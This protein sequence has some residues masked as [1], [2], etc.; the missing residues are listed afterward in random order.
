MS[1]TGPPNPLPAGGK[2]S[3]NCTVIS[4]FAPTVYW[5]DPNSQV[6]T[7]E[8]TYVKI[9]SPVTNGNT[10]Y[11]VLHFDAINTSHG[12]TYACISTVRE[13]GSFRRETRYIQV[14]SE[15]YLC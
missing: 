5:L 3:L 8:G 1:I 12:G 13:T 9:D 6:I 2:Y 11:V 15:S 7:T 4:D 14:Q 10:T